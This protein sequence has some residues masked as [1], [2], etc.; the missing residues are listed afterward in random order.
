VPVIEDKPFEA[1]NNLTPMVEKGRKIEP[2]ALIDT[3]GSNSWPAVH[4]GTV[5][6]WEM[7]TE[8]FQGIVGKLAAADSEAENEEEGG[9]IMTVT[10]ASPPGYDHSC[11]VVGDINQDNFAEQWKT[12]DIGGGTYVM[13]GWDLMLTNFAEEFQ[14]ANPL[15]VMGILA[16]TD[17]E[18]TDLPEFAAK[19][20]GVDESVKMVLAVHGY[21]LDHDRAVTAYRK[22]EKAHPESLRVIQILPNTPPEVVADAMLALLGLA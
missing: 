16:V 14:D 1:V 2:V 5:T 7:V 18:M 19:I 11:R 17:G 10:F 20:S 3:S 21:G 22:V 4:G 9:G 13:P 8:L 15:P 6:R 12:I